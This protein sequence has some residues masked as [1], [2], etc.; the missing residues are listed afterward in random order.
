MIVNYMMSLVLLDACELR[1]GRSHT[2]I[3]VLVEPSEGINPI[4][5]SVGD[6]SIHQTSRFVADRDQDL[7]PVGIPIAFAGASESGSHASRLAEVRALGGGRGCRG[8]GKGMIM[9]G[10]GGED[11]GGQWGH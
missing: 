1:Y 10:G 7:G 8:P 5:A 2:F 4:I 9:S 3:G 11:G 6:G